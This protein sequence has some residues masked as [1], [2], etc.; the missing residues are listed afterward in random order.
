MNILYLK[1]FREKYNI[2]RETQAEMLDVT[3]DTLNNW[4]Y[5][6]EHKIPTDFKLY[7]F[8]HT[9]ITKLY[10]EFR[11]G[12]TKKRSIEKLSIITGHSSNAINNYITVNDLEL[13]EDYSE[14][15]K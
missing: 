5:R 7:S 8:K 6:T 15:L 3:I 10:L 14:M 11:K 9:F 2:D 13:P 12:Y 4:E 1:D